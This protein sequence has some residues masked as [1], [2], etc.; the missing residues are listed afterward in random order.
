M[1]VQF[2]KIRKSL[3][4][5]MV[6]VLFLLP[7]L[8]IKP[9]SAEAA[10]PMLGLNVKSAILVEATTGKI[11]YKYNENQ[12]FPPASMTK[13]MTEYLLLDSIKKGKVKWD[14]TVVTDEY[15][16][17][18]GKNDGSSVLLAQGDQHTVRQLYEAMAIYSANDATVMLAKTVAGTEEE[19]VKLMNQKAKEF[20]MEQTHFA[21]ATGYPLADLKQFAPPSATGDNVMSARDAAI[22]AKELLTNHPEILQTTSTPRKMFREGTPQALKMDNWNWMLPGL[23]S[24]YPGV[25]GLKTGHTDAA[26]FCFTGTAQRNGIRFITVVMGADSELKR[27]SE[28][29]KLLDYAFSTYSMKQLLPANSVVPGGEKAKVIRGTSKEVPVVTSKEV[30]YP[31]QSGEEKTY[32]LKAEVKEATAPVKKGQALGTVTVT[33]ANGKTDEFLRPSDQKKAGGVLVAQEDVEEAGWLRLTF[34]AIGQFFGSVFSGIGNTVKG[35]VS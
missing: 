10:G 31:M 33:G 30:L 23:V 24:Y 14:Q 4:V 12:A 6:F 5:T 35:W 1:S 32:K 21:T 17:L 26:K 20:G 13:M 25:D 19:F 22:L 34:R 27:F 11:L 28:T 15:G 29:K 18:L 9:G 7:L 3:T 16:A 2:T 8:T